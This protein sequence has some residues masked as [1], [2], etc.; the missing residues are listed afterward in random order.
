MQASVKKDG[1]YA[2]IRIPMDEIH[3]LRVAL[4]PCPCRAAKS[5]STKDI[6]ESLASA[7]G[8]LEHSAKG[9]GT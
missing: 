8:R 3:G 1:E 6:R 4:R 9:R 7:L 5:N 2:I